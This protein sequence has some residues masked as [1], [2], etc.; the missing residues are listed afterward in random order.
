MGY[1]FQSWS[2]VKT[3][4]DNWR[5]GRGWVGA[6]EPLIFLVFFQNFP[7]NLEQYYTIKIR[8]TVDAKFNNQNCLVIYD[9][10]NARNSC[11]LMLAK[12]GALSMIMCYKRAISNPLFQILSIF[13]VIY[14]S[15]FLRIECKLIMIDANGCSNKVQPFF[16]LSEHTS[17]VSPVIFAKMQSKPSEMQSGHIKAEF[18]QQLK[19]KQSI[20]SN[21]PIG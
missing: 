19:S 12:A 11:L 13:A 16:L 4:E 9:T 18:P 21:Q 1:F 7:D 2:C 8:S 5:V 3:D 17:V 14:I 10:R 6:T 20:C 15:F